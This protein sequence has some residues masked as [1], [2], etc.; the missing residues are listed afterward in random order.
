VLTC[1]TCGRENPDDAAFCM[2]CATPLAPGASAREQ[3]KTI[4][5]LFCDLVGSTTLAERHDP[6][7]LR[8]LLQ[9]YFEAMRKAVERHGG[10]VEKFIGDAVVAVFG[11]PQIHEDDALRAVRAASE[12]RDGLAALA[13]GSAVELVCRIGITT[14]EVLVGGEDQPLVGDP[15][16]TAARLQTAAEPG[17]I[18]I[19][20][21]TYRLVRDAVLAEPVA[22]LTLK[23]KTGSV[24]AHRLLRVASLSPMRA[25]RLDAPM[26]GRERE[27]GLLRQ[28]FERTVSD[29]ACHLFTVLGAAGAGKSR[30]V[31]EFLTPLDHADVMRGRC[32][33][34]G[35]GITFFPVAEAMKET[36]GLGDFDGESAVQDRIHAALAGEE[37]AEEI[38]ANLAKLLGAGAGGAAEET[39]WAIRRF[40]EARGRSRPVVVVFDD[41]HWGEPTFL[42]LVEHVADWS[43]EASILLLCMAR[44]DLLDERPAW[45]GG[46][47]NATTISL[48]PLSDEECVE[49]I[50]HL[51]GSSGL[52]LEVR[53][54]ITMVSEGNPLFVEEMLRMMIDDQLLKREGDRWIPAR[55]L[56]DVSVP[57]TISALLSARL[58]RLSEHERDVLERA[59]VCGKEFH[60][61]AVVELLPE[62]VRPEADVLL[63][64]LVRRDLVGP[65]RSLLPGEEAYRFRHLL[66]RDAAYDAIPKHERADLHEAFATWLERVAGDRVVEQEEILGYH[67]ERACR[68]RAELGS[69]DERDRTIARRASER[70]GAAGKRSY[71]RGDTAAAINLLSRAVELTPPQ[72]ADR[73]RLGL[74]L[75]RSLA[76]AGKEVKALGV[77]EETQRVSIG[78]GDKVLQMHA[79]LALVELRAWRDPAV[80]E[81]WRSGAERAIGVFETAED[82]AG[83]ARA[84]NVLAWHHVYRNHFADSDRAAARGLIHAR[85]SGDR[86]LELELLSLMGNVVW[87]PM[88]ATE[89]FARC[90]ELH[91]AAAGN[92]SLE[93]MQLAH[94]ASLIAMRGEI[95]EARR[96]WAEGKAMTDELG[97]L[98]ESAFSVQ[99][100]WYIEMLARDFPRAE[101]LTR[102]EYVRLLEAGSMGLI[103]ITRD[104]MALAICAQG[105]FDEADELARETELQPLTPEDVTGQNVWRRIRARALSTRGEH[106]EAIRLAREAEALFHGT[107]ALIDHGEALLDLAGVLRSAGRAED[108]SSAATEALALYQRKENLVEI[109]R[110]RAFL[111]D[112][113]R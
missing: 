19:G 1:S 81:E 53:D 80:V 23:G 79:E 95:Q 40:I 108:A 100:G 35:D 91:V 47:T 104:M 30:L 49:L 36:L 48:A 43:R 89:G 96:V 72:G 57:P 98:T 27:D 106:E 113:E 46:K 64:S 37:H 107:D 66:I 5:V 58:D 62:S 2:S 50:D 16:N 87:G 111:A 3:R 75:G 4:T 68:L 42:D 33:A 14:G 97:R 69:V 90:D 6:E 55:P 102:A 78:T 15:M 20:E 103:D 76:W 112:I 12:M 94:R 38:T 52:P 10:R 45:A 85:A 29:R 59:A 101:E 83:L 17:E 24:P 26:V 44:P 110:A 31:E 41:I 51:L 21:P 60:R 61:G 109:E 65:E 13:E 7:V 70:L 9:R 11:M 105:R 73:V 88:R 86:G 99:E 22:P 74:S 92:R 56:E 93:G 39:F 82:E 32:L 63:R 77:L 34:Y 8:P 67:L 54:R 71:E 28:A 18:L 25:R 84:W